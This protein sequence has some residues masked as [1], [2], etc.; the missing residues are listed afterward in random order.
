MEIG[1]Q[2]FWAGAAT[3]CKCS[4]TDRPS[5]V[6][7]PNKH[8]PAEEKTEHGLAALSRHCFVCCLE[9]GFK[10]FWHQDGRK[11]RLSFSGSVQAAPFVFSWAGFQAH[12][13][14]TN[15]YIYIHTLTQIWKVSIRS[16]QDMPRPQL[17][18]G[19]QPW[20]GASFEAGNGRNFTLGKLHVPLCIQRCSRWIPGRSKWQPLVSQ[21]PKTSAQS[22]LAAA[23]WLVQ[24]GPAR[25][26]RMPNLQSSDV[27]SFQVQCHSLPWSCHLG[28]PCRF[29][30]L[31]AAK[32][33]SRAFESHAAW[34]TQ[35]GL[36]H[37]VP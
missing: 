32:C 37:V 25:V 10:H 26:L 33:H 35:S 19:N 13:T 11:T 21:K 16:S 34:R 27:V 29:R 5:I 1:L 7:H 20:A 31:G 9:G 18:E 23:R 2:P 36:L 17:L 12:W 30:G 22:A 28:M 24:F 4:N 8:W 6:A 15:V 3:D 14:D